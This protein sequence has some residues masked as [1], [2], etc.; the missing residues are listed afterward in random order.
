M[1]RSQ[2][3]LSWS[4]G[5][6]DSA[7]GTPVQM[8]PA[9]VPG[10]VQ[11]DWA[12]ASG[13][14]DHNY[15]DNFKLYDW[16]WKKHWRYRAELSIPALEN[17][18][19]VFFV[20]HGIDYDYSILL[21]GKLLYD[22]EGMFTPVEL[23]LT[24]KAQ[25]GDILEI[26]IKPA[27][28]SRDYSTLRSPANRSA[29][30]AVSYG[31]DWHPTLVPLG[32]WDETFLE[33]RPEAHF[34]DADFDYTLGDDLS[35]A[36]IQ[37]KAFLSRVPAGARVEFILDGPAGTM[38]LRQSQEAA[39][40]ITF[41]ASLPFPQLWWPHDH[42]P[43]N[44][45]TATLRLLSAG[46]TVIDTHRI[47]SGFRKVRMIM[48]ER[49]WEM[50]GECPATQHPAPFTLEI[51]NRVIFAKGSNWVAPEIF[52]GTI[53]AATYHPLLEAAKA[54]H[55]NLLRSWGG[56]M[57][58]KESFFD[59]CDVLGL[60]VWQEFPLSCNCYP[61]DTAYLQVLDKE[62][63]AMIKRIKHHPCRVLW[64][65]GN[66]LF[67][68]WSRMSDQS[69]ALRLLNR[70]CY[71][72]DQHTPFIYTSPVYGVRH[73]DYRFRNQEGEEVYAIFP[74][75]QATAYVEF[76]VP[77]PSDVDYLK[78][79]IPSEELFPPREGTAWEWHHALKAWDANLSSWLFPET[80]AH[81]FGEPES[82]EV[83]VANGQWLQCE[84]YKALFEEARR[85]KPVCS[86]ALNW[87]YNEP[88]PSA[89]NNSILNYPC[90]HKPAYYAVQASCR[91]ILASARI[92][93]FTWSAGEL[94][95]CQ[96]WLLNDRYEKAKAGEVRAELVLDEG[97]PIP[98]GK[99]DFTALEPNRNQQG[100]ALSM[101]LPEVPFRK[102]TL[103]L[104]VPSKPEWDSYYDLLGAISSP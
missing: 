16:T 62:S 13:M 21:N 15:G 11:L 91:P 52:P 79:F 63:R 8:V 46:N 19:R 53:T 6:A 81:Y 83:L 92:P 96:L 26:L 4:V 47:K 104:R 68:S 103:R 78:S 75:Y 12:K 66:E 50:Y 61:D 43:Q 70:N 54:A 100:P 1:D 84:G 18:K 98:L 87:C 10:A 89:A 88:W 82:L 14:P 5:F 85:Q 39:E 93:K 25:S 94:F 9:A 28:D 17:G 64:C 90:R 72:L 34:T 42:G 55:F 30:P 45:Y 23:D 40:A 29:K 49:A 102:L 67:N 22:H 20:S 65:G 32:I 37:L 33:V 80:L 31:W 57:L 77:G 86:M 35:V 95:S 60:M 99:W 58:S 73:G 44:R 71:D 3:P 27:P 76:G 69:H 97:Q 48:H 7:S 38:V 2:I 36:H 51:N 56:A 59:Q 41:K 24:G 101:P 74:R